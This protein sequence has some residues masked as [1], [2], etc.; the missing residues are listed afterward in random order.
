LSEREPITTPA[1]DPAVAR[2]HSPLPWVVAGLAVL[3]AVAVLLGPGAT[4]A[5]W[6]TVRANLDAWRA[7]SDRH[8]FAALLIYFAAYAVCASLPLPV[9]TVASLLGGFL[10]GP[11]AGAAVASLAYVTGV[12]AAFLAARGLL[13]ER[14]RRRFDGPRLRRVEAGFARDGAYYLLAL[15][16]MPAMPFFVVNWLMAL[17]PI[18]TRTFSVVSWVGVLPLTFLYAGVGTELASIQTPGDV[19]SLPVVASLAALAVAPLLIRALVRAASK[20]GRVE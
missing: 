17:T 18:R 3:A 9:L 14:V 13:R 7:W 2:P 11:L 19:L 8:L 6:E 10:F 15:R 4:A 20:G 5:A 12:T 1:D 16:L